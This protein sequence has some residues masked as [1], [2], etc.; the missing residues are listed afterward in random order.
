MLK[1]REI[2]VLGVFL[3]LLTVTVAVDLQHTIS[4][5][6]GLQAQDELKLCTL[7]DSGDNKTFTLI[8]QKG[9]LAYD[10]SKKT[11]E[12]DFQFNQDQNTVSLTVT[13]MVNFMSNL[14]KLTK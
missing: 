3:S 9:K 10:G 12:K 1:S 5:R 8:E 13:G 14:S 4:Q 6:R 2:T 7:T 11:D